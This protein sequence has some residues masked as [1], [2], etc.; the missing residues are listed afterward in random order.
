MGDQIDSDLIDIEYFK[1]LKLKVGKILTAESV[2]KSNKLIKL[3]VSFGDKNKTI[4][5]GI[6]KFYTPESLINK[7]VV[8]VDNLKPAK[9]FGMDS[10]GMI[11]A[12]IDDEGN[13]ALLCPDKDLKEGSE[14]S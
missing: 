13:L 9:L 8:I 6:K 10:E 14:V 4:L 11:L 2:E 7:K 1:K 5:S 3:T 12:A